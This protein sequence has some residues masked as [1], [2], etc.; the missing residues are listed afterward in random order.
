MT[1]ILGCL[2]GSGAAVGEVGGAGDAEGE[3]AGD[4]YSGSVFTSA[5][6]L[7]GGSPGGVDI[8]AGGVILRIGPPEGTMPGRRDIGLEVGGIGEGELVKEGPGRGP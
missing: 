2:G 7:M 8:G 1:F 6:I 3:P 4:L 5:L